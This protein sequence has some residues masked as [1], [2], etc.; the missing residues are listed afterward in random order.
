[1][2]KSIFGIVLVFI[3]VGCGK[4]VEPKLN[5]DTSLLILK[6]SKNDKYATYIQAKIDN[7][8]VDTY[9]SSITNIR[10]N[11]GKHTITLDSSIYYG[12]QVK[13]RE[14]V[15]FILDFK[16]EK[17]YTIDLLPS[18]LKGSK[19]DN[20]VGTYRMFENKKLLLKKDFIFKDRLLKSTISSDETSS[21]QV[22]IAV[23]Q[24]VVLGL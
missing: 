17:V 3:L 23:I 13:R 16:A 15:K 14:P 11:L 10:V 24:S 5:G 7:Q 6:D 21:E 20:I 22:A 1:M 2:K 4:Y 8:T 19:N 9:K 12:S 18:T